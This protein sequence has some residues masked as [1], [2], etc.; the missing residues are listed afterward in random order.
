[1]TLEVRDL[2]THPEMSEGLLDQRP[3]R[4]VEVGD[5]DCRLA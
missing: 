1:M 5:A 3:R 2:A 4:V